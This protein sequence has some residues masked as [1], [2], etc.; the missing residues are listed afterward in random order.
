MIRP[1][2]PIK[3]PIR[4]IRP[5]IRPFRPSIVPIREAIPLKNLLLFGHCQNRK[6][7]RI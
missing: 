5:L 3:P 4:P 7:V 6:T 2:K 1:I